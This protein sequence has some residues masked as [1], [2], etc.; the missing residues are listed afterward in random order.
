MPARKK[1]TVDGDKVL[2]LGRFQEDDGYVSE[3]VSRIRTRR[4][5][6]VVAPSFGSRLHEV[7][8]ATSDAKTLAERYCTIAVGPMVQQRKI[9]DVAVE[10]TLL[11]PGNGEVYFNVD[12]SYFDRLGRRQTLNYKHRLGS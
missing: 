9:R 3:F 2:V 12:A 10:V 5:S 8:K 6:I 11:R 1:K 7:K 4:G